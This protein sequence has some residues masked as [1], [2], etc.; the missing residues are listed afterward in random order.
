MYHV[1]ARIEQNFAISF[2]VGSAALWRR[3]G[4]FYGRH[5]ES[6]GVTFCAHVTEHSA[7]VPVWRRRRCRRD[8]ML[9][10]KF[11][12]PTPTTR[13]TKDSLCESFQLLYPWKGSRPPNS[14]PNRAVSDLPR[15][16]RVQS[17]GK[18]PLPV[19]TQLNPT[20]LAKWESNWHLNKNIP[21]C[22]SICSHQTAP[23]DQF[24]HPIWD[25]SAN[26]VTSTWK[27]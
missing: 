27:T 23:R 22:I 2:L 15:A 7:G 3:R 18:L 6:D 14:G 9:N 5:G 8:R 21:I 10:T 4:C 11:K 1:H 24:R 26:H 19:Y 16:I 12:K 13:K 17:V 25:I 20:K